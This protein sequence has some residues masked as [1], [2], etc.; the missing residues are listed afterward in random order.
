MML[1]SSDFDKISPTAL[2]VAYARQFGDIA[3]TQE[4]ARLSNAEETASKFVLPGQEQPLTVMATIM[5]ARYK[6]IEQVRAK[7][8]HCQ[9]LELASGL[10]PRGMIVSKNPA[11][12]YIESDLAL[13][14]QQ[15]QRLVQQLISDRPNL[16]FLAI[17]ATDHQNFLSLN[18]FFQANQP[19]TV[20]CEGLLMYLTFPEKQRVF[21]NVH[22]I[23][24]TYG[25]VWITSD[26]MTKAMVQMRRSNP[27]TKQFFEKIESAT[28]RLWADNEFE[29]L[30]HAK[31]FA[32]E[33]GFQVEVL[34]MLEV[35]DQLKSLSSLEKLGIDRD[36]AKVMLSVSPIFA[37]K[38]A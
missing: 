6:A 34:S 11:I 28:E 10:L 26:F 4:I 1:P 29:D 37:L 27:I 9:V 21:A 13:M 25:G 16:H 19:V 31:A 7:F 8:N 5:E 36:R 38:L 22:Q 23:L 20:L 15:K 14:I 2:L 3:Y 18:Q 12:T 32:Q 17:D 33:Q 24:Q 30:D 35:M